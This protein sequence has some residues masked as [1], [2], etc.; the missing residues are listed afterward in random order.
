PKGEKE[1]M[2]MLR[3]LSGKRHSVITGFSLIDID[4]KKIITK[5]VETLVYFRKLSERE[6]RE[7]VKRE[8]VYDKA[9]AYAVQGIGATFIEKIEGDYSNIVGLP[10]HAIALEL[11]RFGVSVL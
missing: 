11:R 3:R 8:K 10:L 7:Y 5:S 2:Q 9:G 6:I 1:A 4:S